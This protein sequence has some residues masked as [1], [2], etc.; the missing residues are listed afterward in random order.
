MTEIRELA[1][2]MTAYGLTRL[3]YEKD[4]LR[5]ALERGASAPA[6]AIAPAA[7]AAP[8]QTAETEPPTAGTAVKAPLVGVVYGAREPGA[9]P[10]VTVGQAVKT[11]DTVCV[12]EAMKM[13]CEIAAPC[14]GTVLEVLFENGEL[15]EFGATLLTIG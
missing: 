10:F 15:A 11:G 8:A 7:V 9:E 6:A 2:L 3:E 12:I 13:F 14:D 4:G 5:V 1:D